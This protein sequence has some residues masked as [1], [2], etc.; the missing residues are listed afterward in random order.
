MLI[1]LETRQRSTIYLNPDHI[2]AI[3]PQQENNKLSYRIYCTDS[4]EFWLSEHAGNYLLQFVDLNDGFVSSADLTV[5]PQSPPS[6]SSLSI[7]IAQLLRD[8][9]TNATA[10]HISSTL[11]IPLAETAAALYMLQAERIVLSYKDQL[12]KQI[13][14]YHAS[15]RSTHRQDAIITPCPACKGTGEVPGLEAA[16]CYFCEGSGE[17]NT[18]DV[19]APAPETDPLSVTEALD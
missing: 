4:R 5:E 11:N 3:T 8:S 18:T 2:I 12:D 7:R 16:I 15:Q 13:R 19:T 10:E 14:F 17:M 1:Q 6:E 9:I